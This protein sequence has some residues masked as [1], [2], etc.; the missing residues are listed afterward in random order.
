MSARLRFHVYMNWPKIPRWFSLKTSGS[1]ASAYL[2]PS[3]TA[4]RVEAQAFGSKE[5][6]ERV[7]R[8]YA[9]AVVVA[10]EKAS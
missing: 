6:A 9:G 3:W 2:E 1:G 5:E 7:A 4:E 10:S 8:Q